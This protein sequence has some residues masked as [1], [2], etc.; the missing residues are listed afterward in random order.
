MCLTYIYIHY[1]HVLYESKDVYVFA[2]PQTHI[3]SIAESG[4]VVRQT[5]VINMNASTLVQSTQI[6]V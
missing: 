6:N 5:P 1:I 3:C 4:C 2:F